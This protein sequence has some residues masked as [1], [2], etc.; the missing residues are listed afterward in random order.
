MTRRNDLISQL[1]Q[2]GK[3]G[4]EGELVIKDLITIATEKGVGTLVLNLLNDST[5]F[6]SVSDIENDLID[7]QEDEDVDPEDIVL[8]EEMLATINNVN[9]ETQVLIT[10]ITDQGTTNFTLDR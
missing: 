6:M 9:F 3:W 5:T 10:L 1:I 2:S 7:C 8:L 4:E